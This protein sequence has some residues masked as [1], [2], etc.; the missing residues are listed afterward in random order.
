MGGDCS[1]DRVSLYKHRTRPIADPHAP[2]LQALKVAWDQH[3]DQRLGQLIV[4]ATC[5]D[6]FYIEDAALVGLLAEYVE[7]VTVVGIPAPRRCLCESDPRPT[8]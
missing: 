8:R 3:P 6:P 1:G 2:I 7:T 5:V 4:N